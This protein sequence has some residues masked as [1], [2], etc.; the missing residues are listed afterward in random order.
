ME[1]TTGRWSLRN[2]CGI[3]GFTSKSWSPGAARIREATATLVHRGPDQQGVFH[4]TACSLGA[5]R[6]KIVDLSGG[7]QPIF[8]EDDS[9]LIVFNG[10]IYN[11][12]EVRSEL[13][14]L[15]HSFAS[16]CDTETVLHAF[17]EWDVECFSRLR[18]MFAVALWSKTRRRLVL[19]RDRMGIKPLYIARLG[20]DIVFGSELKAILVHPEIGRNLSLEGLDCYLSLNYVPSP[21]TLVDGIE[22]LPAGHWLEWQDGRVQSGAYWRVPAIE[23]CEMTLEDAKQN[24]H[25][26][27]EQSVREHLLSDV[28]LGV[29]LSGGVDSST[30]LH[31]A[32]SASSSR[33]KT[34]SITF[35]GRSFDESD[36]IRSAVEHYG[37]E[38]A[39]LD[40]NPQED[41]IGAIEEFAY[42]SDEPTADAGALPVWFLSRLC[43][44]STTVALSGEGADE[45]FAGYLTYRAN[46]LSRR[47][48]HVPGGLRRLALSG[49]KYWPPSDEK[50]GLDYKLRRFLEGSLLPEDQAHV[51]WNGTFSEVEKAALVRA[52][53]PGSLDALLG[54]L[55]E[56]RNG[57]DVA[58]FLNFDQ[59]YYLPDDILVKSDRMSMAHAV[60]VRPPFL[61]HRIIEFAAKIP[62]SLKMRGSQQKYLLKQLMKDKLPASI[63]ERKKVGFDIPAH[64]WLRGPL[65]SLLMDTL[66]HVSSEYS[67]F[68]R[69]DVI[70]NYVRLHLERRANCGYHLWGLIILFL[71][72]KKWK[73]QAAP[74]A[75]PRRQLI[76]AEPG[77]S[78]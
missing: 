22:K 44:Q 58:P 35:H 68:F 51:Y 52:A 20:E 18:G 15:G 41:L 70:Q 17:L 2:L 37:T 27:L 38:H 72:M 19:A 71:W 6:L 5:C 7:D 46:Q 43:K 59:R 26:L 64:D 33:L 50:I 8:A 16:H 34:F 53:L 3:A 77:A 11:H 76:A 49:L 12:L 30:I 75:A 60:E 14:A 69:V 29:W 56:E 42:Y 74:A 39:Q 23:P 10:E 21:W 1:P 45:I 48:R 67:E 61:D 57:D 63:L 54:D 73:I 55:R 66:D 36:Y 31:Y 24:L 65:R 62:T 25:G 32:A 78:R 47:A 40:L 9:A 28:P 4:S 13:E